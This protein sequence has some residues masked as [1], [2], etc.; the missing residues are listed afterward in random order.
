[1][2]G[3]NNWSSDTIFLYIGTILV[4]TVFAVLACRKKL[5]SVTGE[6]EIKVNKFLYLCSAIPPWLLLSLAKCGM[7]YPVYRMMFLRAENISTLLQYYLIEPGFAVLNWMIRLFTDNENIYFGIITFLFLFFIYHGV[8]KMMKAIHPAWGIFVFN[9]I[10][11]LQQMNLKRVYL[12][13]AILFWSMSFLVERKYIKYVIS[14]LI[15]CSIHT[16][17][18]I[19]I[20][21]LMYDLILYKKIS[22][23]AMFFLSV[24]LL[25]VLYLLR[26]QIVAIPISQRYANYGTQGTGIGFLQILYHIPIFYL[27]IK[28]RRFTSFEV[29]RHRSIAFINTILSFIIGMMGYFIVMIGRALVYFMYPIMIAASLNS[30]GYIRRKTS[31]ISTR[32]IWHIIMVIYCILRLVLYANQYC[33]AD[34]IMPYVD[35]FGKTY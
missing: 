27:L 26:N 10:F 9:T 32:N 23:R 30:I 6:V 31:V 13:A 14:V 20:A 8:Y 22:K 29:D 24:C 3:T 19:M 15:C 11:L 18:I 7:D 28:S 17:A 5:N 16:S 4:S 12:A 2:M 34:G 35:I 33:Y 21:P 1:M 25:V